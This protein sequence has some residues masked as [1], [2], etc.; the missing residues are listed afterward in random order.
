MK[1]AVSPLEGSGVLLKQ[2]H[3]ITLATAQQGKFGVGESVNFIEKI[4]S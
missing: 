2:H 1:L 4:G 3:S